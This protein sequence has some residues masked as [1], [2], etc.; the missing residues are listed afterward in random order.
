MD[1]S[2]GDTKRRSLLQ[3]NFPTP[4]TLFF[5]SCFPGFGVERENLGQWWSSSSCT[6]A[7]TAAQDWHMQHIQG[8]D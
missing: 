3:N 5:V 6:L 7:L 8:A 1:H 2:C 4:D